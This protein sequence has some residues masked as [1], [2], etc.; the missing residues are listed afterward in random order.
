MPDPIT[1]T[2]PEISQTGGMIEI[3][4]AFLSDRQE[5]PL[6]VRWPGEIPPQPQAA[7]D[8]MLSFGLIPAMAQGRDLHIAAAVSPR[9]LYQ[10]ATVQDIILR[11]Y[12]ERFRRITITSEEGLSSPLIPR[13]TGVATF[14]T[15][16]IDSL[17]TLRQNLGHIDHT[18]YVHG[19]DVRLSDTRHREIAAGACRSATTAI[20]LPLIEVETN[21]RH[22]T[23]QSTNWLTESLSSALAGIAH[24]LSGQIGHIFIPSSNTFESLPPLGSDPL[25][26]TQWRSD[27]LEIIHH[28][29]Q[30]SRV[31][32]AAAI[33]DW[34]VA[35]KFLRVCGEN[36]PGQRNCGH[37]EK[38]ARTQLTLQSIGAY[39][40]FADNF[41]TPLSSTAAAATAVNPHNIGNWNDWASILDYAA[42]NGGD[43]ALIATLD[44]KI[45][46]HQNQLLTTDLRP[47]LEAT[48]NSEH[49]KKRWP[50]F[51]NKI[52][53]SLAECDAEW[54][55]N[56]VRKN[57]PALRESLADQLDNDSR[58]LRK[59]L[60]RALWKKRLRSKV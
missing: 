25:L 56:R 58:W 40:D 51:R 4:A 33:A 11:W 9:L 52:L 10:S 47:F 28:G 20:G 27:R 22:Y 29:C 23:D 41:S 19:Y 46:S 42:T 53:C 54:F 8:A 30:A 45:Q 6:F 60:R 3:T 16:G 38:C 59:K 49:W 12:P 50:K 43:P 21:L 57:L 26:D 1:I 7:G 32:K 34:A 2:T 5:H 55:D 48:I 14:F 37:C 31:E 44:A 24:L 35:Q 13:A 39:Q 15:S 17:F 36:T 18:I